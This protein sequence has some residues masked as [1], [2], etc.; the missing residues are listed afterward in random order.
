M[1]GPVPVVRLAFG[2]FG[3]V[4]LLISLTIFG[5]AAR[6]IALMSIYF[7][8]NTRLPMCATSQTPIS[9]ATPVINRWLTTEAPTSL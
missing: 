3:W 8:G 6:Q 4:S 9:I 7:A 1:V 2:S 5:V